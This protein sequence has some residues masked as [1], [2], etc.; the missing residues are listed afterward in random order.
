MSEIEIEIWQTHLQNEMAENR[1]PT[2]HIL[3]AGKRHYEK[4]ITTTFTVGAENRAQF[5]PVSPLSFPLQL[6]LQSQYG[7]LK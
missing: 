3:S 7:E 6:F 5:N 4:G 1:D 2:E